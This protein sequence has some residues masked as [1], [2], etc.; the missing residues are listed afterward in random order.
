MSGQRPCS[1]P[2]Y[3]AAEALAGPTVRAV[4]KCGRFAFFALNDPT[5]YCPACEY[6]PCET[7]DCVPAHGEG[8][9]E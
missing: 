5:P 8:T 1:H 6:Q 2:N 7:C 9:T 3:K 4:C